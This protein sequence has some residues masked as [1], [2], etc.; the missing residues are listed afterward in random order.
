MTYDDMIKDQINKIN[1][2][3]ASNSFLDWLKDIKT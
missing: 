3:T 2:L 1:N